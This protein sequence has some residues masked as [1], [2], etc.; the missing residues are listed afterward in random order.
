MEPTLAT[1]VNVTIIY[2]E[3][4]ESYNWSYSGPL[5]T[6]NNLSL[7]TSCQFVLFVLDA[8]SAAE[9]SFSGGQSPSSQLAFPFSTAGCILMT[10]AQVP[11]NQPGAV[12]LGTPT[13]WAVPNNNGGGPFS[14][15][16]EVTNTGNPIDKL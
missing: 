7:P 8:T 15:G 10:D 5:V 12:N 9:Y 1:V 16:P 2:D 6:D 13:L 11:G 4:S 14:G 3:E